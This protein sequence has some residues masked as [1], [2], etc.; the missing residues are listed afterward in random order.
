M[1]SYG[2]DFLKAMNE[3]LI[4]KIVAI[5]AFVFCLLAI[6]VYVISYEQFRYS[7]E[8]G[9]T[10]SATLTTGEIV[11]G[12]IIEQRLVAP[13]ESLTSLEFRAYVYDRTNKGV[14]NI[15]LLDEDRNLLTTAEINLES[16]PNTNDFMSISFPVAV[17]SVPGGHYFVQLYTQGCSHGNAIGLYSGNSVTTGRFDVLKEI[18]EE[19]IYTVNGEQGEG[20][21]CLRLVGITELGFYKVYWI[22]IAVLLACFLIYSANS[23]RKFR[24]GRN[25]YLLGLATLASKYSFL[26]KQLVIRDFKIKYKRSSLGM[27]WS[28]LNP[29]LSMSVQYVVFSTLF[30][31]DIPN[32]PVY[33][34]VGIVMFNFFNEALSAGIVSITLNAPLIKKVYI[35]KYI[36]PFSKLC[37]STVNFALSFIPIFLVMLL[38]GTSF[39]FSL[40]LLVF[41]LLCLFMFILGMSLV[42]STMNTFFQDTQFLWNVISM[43][44]MYATPIFYPESIIPGKLLTLYHMNPMYQYI[45]FAR[46]AIIDGISPAPT[47]YLWCIIPSV[48]VFLFGAYVFKKNQDKFVLYL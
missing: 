43:I 29:L 41:D 25:S 45:T 31:S 15:R 11:D 35:P 44:W 39:H 36:Y 47:A 7:I 4:R 12:E 24:N 32:Y 1:H 48:V 13:A 28:F 16:L 8:Q 10:L 38:T 27:V 5:I 46:V 37:S 3:S 34:L 23:I 17:E 21:L 19:D 6:L 40:L 22:V 30:R 9:D 42:L 14:M 18:S 20:M 33:L 26:M 2:I